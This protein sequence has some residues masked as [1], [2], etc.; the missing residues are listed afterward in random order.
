MYN[1]SRS[2]LPGRNETTYKVD[3]VPPPAC[4]PVRIFRLHPDDRKAN[5]R[6]EPRLGYVADDVEIQQLESL[7]VGVE[8]EFKLSAATVLQRG[9]RRDQQEDAHEQLV[10][11]MSTVSRAVTML[12]S[13]GLDD[14]GFG[15]GS[16]RL[17]LSSRSSL[18][19]SMIESA[20]GR[21]VLAD[22]DLLYSVPLLD[23]KTG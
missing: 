18:C 11:R 9:S 17:G 13:L 19:K 15:E 23:S 10:P 6:G 21:T 20:L 8:E 22:V 3:D 16:L 14:V 2:G 4:L 12:V 5:E 1:S 7:A